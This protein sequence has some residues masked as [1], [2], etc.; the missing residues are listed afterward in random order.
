MS[1]SSRKCRRRRSANSPKAGSA[2]AVHRSPGAP[3]RQGS[4]G[5]PVARSPDPG[6]HRITC[7]SAHFEEGKKMDVLA[8]YAASQPDKLAVIDDRP[9][10]PAVSWSF[11]GASTGGPHRLSHLISLGVDPT[12]KVVWCGQNSAG[13]LAA[14]HAIGKIGAV[15]VPLNYRLTASEAALRHRQLRRLVVLRRRRVRRPHLPDRRS[16]PQRHRR[17]RLRR[18]R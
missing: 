10:Q 3:D 5:P 8:R 6:S 4:V 17:A 1:S 16:D 18:R 11:A 7:E 14:A 13:L 9:G 12:T 15:A 2:Q